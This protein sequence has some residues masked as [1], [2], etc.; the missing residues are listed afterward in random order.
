MFYRYPVNNAYINYSSHVSYSV[1]NVAI[2][3]LTFM[4]GYQFSVFEF[5][6]KLDI[7]NLTAH[8]S[9]LHMAYNHVTANVTPSLN[10][11]M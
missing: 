2:Y 8:L 3:L 6:D 10:A 1:K 9:L 4:N 7:L 5:A 11:I